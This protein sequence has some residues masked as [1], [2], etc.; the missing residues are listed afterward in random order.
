MTLL[1]LGLALF[2]GCHSAQIFASGPRAAFIAQRGPGPWK[3]LYAVASL[4]G[5]GLIIKGYGD[6]RGAAA[7]WPKPAGAQH[8]TALLVLA[9]FILQ[10][11]AYWP[12]NAIKAAV[13]DPMVLGV[14]FWAL[15]H[16]LVKSSPPALA[17][18]GGFLV[19]AALDFASLR[20]R[21]G[22]V[23]STAAPG[24]SLVATAGTIVVGVLLFVAFAVWGH[25]L[26]IGVRPFG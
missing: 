19:W 20:R 8:V 3:G 10:V 15:G 25:P 17:L 26:L 14:G 9:G 5:F 7:L 22:G 11:A 18:F 13:R 12:R 24:S 16:L 6:A 23:A 1:L 2:L 21:T 4:I